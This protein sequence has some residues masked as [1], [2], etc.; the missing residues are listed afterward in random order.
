METSVIR[1]GQ[2]STETKNL[3]LENK[4]NL[5]LLFHVQNIVLFCHCLFSLTEKSFLFQKF[6]NCGV[7]SKCDSGGTVPD[8]R[9]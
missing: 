5:I 7:A 2:Q 3:R 9:G 6:K 8:R 4:N 1:H